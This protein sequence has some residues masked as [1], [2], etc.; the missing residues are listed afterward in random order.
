[1][2]AAAAAGADL[3]MF[4]NDNPRSEDPLAI[5]A[6]MIDG[7]SAGADVIVEPDRRVAIEQA[8]AP[9]PRRTMSS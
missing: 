7:V 3:A 1:M 8:V 9:R 4:T 6:A 2:G 5:L